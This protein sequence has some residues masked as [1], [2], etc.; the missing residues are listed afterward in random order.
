MTQDRRS[1]IAVMA[2]SSG[3]TATTIQRILKEDLQLVKRCAKFMPYDITDTQKKKRLDICDFLCRLHCHTPR[4]FR[5]AIT[6]DESW[7]YVYDPEL[8]QQSKEWM[9]KAEA[10]PQK[11]R[12]TISNKVMIIILMHRDLSTTNSY[13]SPSL[14]QGVFRAIF[15]RF[16]DTHQ[17]CRPRSTVGGCKFIHMDNAPSHNATLSLQF[18]RGLGWTCLPHPPYSPDLTS[19]DFWFY[20]RLKNLRGQKFANLNDLKASVETEIS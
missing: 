4:V 10:R 7:V 20:Q 3:I 13:N 6:L 8:K 5:H 18:V 17:C 11:P 16:N 19:N 12:R 2:Q 15:Q 14:T 9:M 1:S